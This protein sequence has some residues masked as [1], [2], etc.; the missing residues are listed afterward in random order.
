MY[1]RLLIFGKAST[2]RNWSWNLAAALWPSITGDKGT[3]W[4][5]SLSGKLENKSLFPPRYSAVNYNTGRHDSQAK[6]DLS[7]KLA[8]RAHASVSCGVSAYDVLDGV[9]IVL[10]VQTSRRKLNDLI[11][12]E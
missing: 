6:A 7:E 9:H 12:S 8:S 4:N 11:Y 3:D 1:A 2:Q 5:S 10:G